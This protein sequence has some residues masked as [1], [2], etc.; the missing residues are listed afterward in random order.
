[1]KYERDYQRTWLYRSEWVVADSFNELSLVECWDFL[2]SVISSPEFVKQFPYTFAY[3]A[4]NWGQKS[5]AAQEYRPKRRLVYL[6][7][8]DRRGGLKLRPGYRRRHADSWHSTITLPRWSRNKMTL[9]HE[10]AHICS[11]RELPNGSTVSAHGKEFAGIYLFLVKCF[12]GNQVETALFDAMKQ[13]Q[14]KVLDIRY[15]IGTP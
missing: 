2:T 7:H 14:V 12:L 10:L 15:T 3:L 9:L 8:G 5:P 1:M 13:H 4:K 6:H 11:G